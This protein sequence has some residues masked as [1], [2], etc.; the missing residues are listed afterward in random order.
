MKMGLELR[1][2]PESSKNFEAI[3]S[4]KNVIR[5]SKNTP[6]KKGGIEPFEVPTISELRMKFPELRILN[7]V[8]LM[9]GIALRAE[10]VPLYSIYTKR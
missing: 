7:L 9:L 1:M 8:P 10:A 3:R 5:S 4:S 6:L 2:N